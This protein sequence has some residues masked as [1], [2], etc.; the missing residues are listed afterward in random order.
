MEKIKANLSLII[1]LS[2]PLLLILIIAGLIYLPRVFSSV[3]PQYDFLYAVGDGVTYSNGYGYI[4]DTYPLRNGMWP[5]YT[6]KVVGNTLMKVNTA[7]AT[8]E[9]AKLP[10]T[11]PSPKFYIHHVAANTNDAVM[12]EQAEKLKLNTDLHS[13]DGFTIERGV[14]NASIFFYDASASS[15]FFL[16]KDAYASELELELSNTNTYY[17]SGDQF[18]LGWIMP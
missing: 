9:Y 2:I 14:S 8:N 6:Y 18:F 17:Y 15:K 10:I 7:T 11:E 13:P 16:K 3:K 4:S 12:F 1:G 5:K